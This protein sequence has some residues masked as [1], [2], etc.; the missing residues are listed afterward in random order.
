MSELPGETRPHHVLV[1]LQRASG[2]GRVTTHGPATGRSLSSY[3]RL[4]SAPPQGRCPLVLLHCRGTI[5]CSAAA[6]APCPSP[7]QHKS[8]SCPQGGVLAIHSSHQGLPRKSINDIPRETQDGARAVARMGPSWPP[9]AGR[10]APLPPESRSPRGGWLSVGLGGV[11]SHGAGHSGCSAAR[12][13]GLCSPR[14]QQRGALSA[15]A[16]GPGSSADLLPLSPGPLRPLVPL[17][18]QQGGPEAP[19][20]GLCRE[21]AAP[22]RVGHHEGHP[23]DGRRHP[24]RHPGVPQGLAAGLHCSP[25]SVWLPGANISPVSTA[26]VSLTKRPAQSHP[27][28]VTSGLSWSQLCFSGSQEDRAQ[29]AGTLT[30]NSGCGSEAGLW[31]PRGVGEALPLASSGPLCSVPGGGSARV[32]C[33]GARA[34]LCP[35]GLCSGRKQP[36]RPQRSLNCDTACSEE[37]DMLRTALGES[38]ASLDSTVRSAPRGALAVPGLG[39]GPALG[40]SPGM[41]IAVPSRLGRPLAMS[42]AL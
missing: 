32:A 35:R 8:H 23:A 9:R 31:P 36:P 38:T 6:G 16:T 1:Q 29:P 41:V 39:G 10:L 18:A 20:G 3:T 22:G 15:A 37:P 30:R 27:Q 24:G 26:L 25:G 17:R 12:V 13:G 7:D 4:C 11:C 33:C 5:L 42:P 19:Q 2:D 28:V 40:A 21:K 14:P 34:T